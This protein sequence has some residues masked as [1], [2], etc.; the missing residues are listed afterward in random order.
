MLDLF[1]ENSADIN[2]ISM[3]GYYNFC[4]FI[5]KYSNFKMINHVLNLNINFNNLNFYNETPIFSML[6]NTNFLINQPSSEIEIKPEKAPT[7]VAIFIYSV[8]L[9][10]VKTIRGLRY[11]NASVRSGHEIT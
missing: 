9:A 2:Y 4:H 5:A 3:D 6:R 11:I 7:T 1:I 8:P 10:V